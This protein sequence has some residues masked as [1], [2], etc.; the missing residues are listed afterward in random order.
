[1]WSRRQALTTCARA[2]G[3]IVAFAGLR[4][5]AL[6]RVADAAAAVGSRS[7]LDTASD[8]DFWR[9]VQQAFAVD[10]TILNLNNGGVGVST[11][12]VH[13]AFKQYLDVSNQ[14]PPHYMWSVVG[15]N[16]DS[17][18]RQLAAAADCDPDE[19]AITRN[20]TEANALVQMGL[21]L[22]RGDEVLMT[23]QEHPGED[24]RWNQRARREGIA[25][26]RVPF[27]TP[28]ASPGS[29]LAALT[30]RMTPRT[31]VLFF[32]HVTWKTGQVF[33]VKE[34][35]AA[36]RSR[37][38]ASIVDGAHGFAHL[39]ASMRELG[40]DYY[41]T[42]LHKW[43][44]APVGTGFLYVRRENIGKVWTL[45]GAPSRLDRDIRKF[46]WSIG[47]HPAANF[48][49]I[50][51]ALSFQ[52]TLGLE[53]KLERLRYLKRRWAQRVTAL[54]NVRLYTSLEAEQSGA[55]AT[56][57]IEGIDPAK[58]AAHLW[59]A[60]RILVVPR[61]HPGQMAGIRVTPHL[62][63]TIAEIDRFGDAFERVARQGL[64]AA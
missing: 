62:Y 52:Q 18:R 29:L 25:L 28:P 56:V 37:G 44:G 21:D 57:G 2:T 13:D 31:K 61:A 22:E 5:D 6:A 48:A 15:G 35:C 34:L 59:S 60:H 8:E 9:E 27:P 33:P 24:E 41:G 58:L 38:I 20:A 12:A 54:P 47:T 43:L 23:D 1:M 63:T 36:A 30:E 16:L 40:C 19:L 51:E 11:R 3:S 26:V 50:A 64:P 45:M 55:I 46:E 10:R 7:A 32:S 14:A 42:S 49:A 17:V 4:A 53:R 39:P